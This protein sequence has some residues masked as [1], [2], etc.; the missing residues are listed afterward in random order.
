MKDPYLLAAA[1]AAFGCLFAKRTPVSLIQRGCIY[2]RAVWLLSCTMAEGAW[3][4]RNRWEECVEESW[5]R[6]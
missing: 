2:V 4:R 6:R 5:R 1:A 3:E